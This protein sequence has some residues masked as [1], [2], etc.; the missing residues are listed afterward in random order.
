MDSIL[1]G[2]PPSFGRY[3]VIRPS[4][5]VS[6]VWIA[7]ND[8]FAFISK[9]IAA[10]EEPCEPGASHDDATASTRES[11]VTAQPLQRDTY[12]MVAIMPGM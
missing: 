11:L 1:S 10:A 3:R 9:L 4:D 2:F 8:Q 6:E 5:G 7:I 12:T